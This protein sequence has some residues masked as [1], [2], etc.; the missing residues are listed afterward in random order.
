[1]RRVSK[2]WLAR[3]CDQAHGAG[4][5]GHTHQGLEQ[6]RN[7]L[8]RKTV[9]AM[10]PLLFDRNQRRVQELAQ[11]CA[12]GLL[13]HTGN[14]GEFARGQRP[15]THQ[16]RERIGARRIAQQ[17]RDACDVGAVFHGSTVDEPL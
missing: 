7:I 6:A 8:V 13:G 14:R 17:G 11:V 16:C 9:V 2:G 10:T 15:I 12:H 5:K 1:M 3:A 4:T